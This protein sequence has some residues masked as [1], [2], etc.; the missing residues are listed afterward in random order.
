MRLVA[1]AERSQRHPDGGRGHAARGPAVGLRRLRQRRRV[2]RQ[3]RAAL[4]A[5]RR[6]QLVLPAT[7][8]PPI[9]N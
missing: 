7:Q 1:D 9:L 2:L 3:R 6:R 4:R 8:I 5:P